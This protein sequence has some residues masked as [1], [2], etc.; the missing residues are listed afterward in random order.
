MKEQNL[1]NLG[2]QIDRIDNLISGFGIP[3]PAQTTMEALKEI[4]PEISNILKE[5]YI[6]ESGENPWLY[7]ISMG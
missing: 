6:E 1:E 5:V 3:I 7:Q 2:L 4:L